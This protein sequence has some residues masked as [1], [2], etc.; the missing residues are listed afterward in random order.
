MRTSSSMVFRW[1]VRRCSAT[2]LW[3]P[4]RCF[5]HHNI[6]SIPMRWVWQKYVRFCAGDLLFSSFFPFSSSV[7][8]PTVTHYQ[9]NLLIFIFF[10][11]NLFFYCYLF[12]FR[13]S[14]QLRF[15]FN[16]IF[17]FFQ[18]SDLVPII[19]TSVFLIIILIE[20]SFQLHRSIFYIIFLIE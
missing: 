19:L 1:H 6:A 14:I 11:F 2:K 18:L 13:L 4:W 17:F 16:L 5:N 15:S 3:P 12:Y 10:G 7:L 8:K 20:L 9:S